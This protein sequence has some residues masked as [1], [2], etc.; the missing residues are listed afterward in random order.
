MVEKP[1]PPLP[2]IPPIPPVPPASELRMEG[3]GKTKTGGT[4]VIA[5]APTPDGK[6]LVGVVKSPLANIAERAG[7]TA[8][9]TFLGALAAVQITSVSQAKQA[10]LAGVAAVGGA[11][12][13]IVKTAVMEYVRASKYGK[14]IG[15][16]A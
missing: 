14:W 4:V 1:I 15:G 12:L 10:A 7:W 11:L 8:L 3:V 13:S 5:P 9:Q 2:A 16:K 6:P